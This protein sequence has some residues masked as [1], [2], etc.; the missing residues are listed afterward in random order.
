MNKCFT[1]L[2]HEQERSNMH[3]SFGPQKDI[4]VTPALITKKAI[5]YCRDITGGS[6]YEL[7]LRSQFSYPQILDNGW[8]RTLVLSFT[9]M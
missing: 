7:N 6:R 3:S 8:N 2:I 1:D 4:V 9:T 5:R